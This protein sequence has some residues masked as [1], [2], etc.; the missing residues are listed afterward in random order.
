MS[1]AQFSTAPSADKYILPKHLIHFPHSFEPWDA[2][3]TCISVS[4]PSSFL[5]KIQSN[6]EFVP[7]TR[8]QGQRPNGLLKVVFP[9][10]QNPLEMIMLGIRLRERMSLALSASLFTKRQRQSTFSFPAP[11][12]MGTIS[13]DRQGAS[14]WS[15]K[16]PKGSP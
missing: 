5:L 12:L 16:W 7:N 15:L 9:T 14:S 2:S 13:V 11:F 1:L 10:V 3:L 8:H 6:Q 4:C